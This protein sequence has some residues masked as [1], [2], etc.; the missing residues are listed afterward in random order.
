MAAQTCKNCGTCTCTG[1]YIVN[2]TNGT[3]CCSACVATVNAQIA[4]GQ[5][6]YPKTK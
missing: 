3:S 2:A 5:N 4:E 6:V 1:T